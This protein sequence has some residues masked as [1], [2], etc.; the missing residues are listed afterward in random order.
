MCLKLD[1]SL[2]FLT[3]ARRG[4]F[5]RREEKRG[6]RDTPSFLVLFKLIEVI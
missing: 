4:I 1:K 5:R 3:C 2:L 6:I